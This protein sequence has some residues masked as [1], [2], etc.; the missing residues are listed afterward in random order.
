[1]RPFR[2]RPI[3][4]KVALLIGAASAMGLLF[5]GVAVLVYELTTFRPRVLQDARTQAEIIRVNSI[6]PLQFNDATAARENLATL[7]NRSEIRSARIW[8]P[9]GRLFAAYVRPGATP[10]TPMPALVAGARFLGDRLV[11]VE[12]MEADGQIIGWLTLQYTTPPLWRRLPQY[13]IMVIVVI[14]ALATAG[15]LLLSMLGRSVSAPL[16]RLADA[17]GTIGRTGNY[18]LQVPRGSD[19][20]IGRLTNAFNQL[21]T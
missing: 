7:E 3:R 16:L 18:R 21:I 11:L 9:D 19:D 14:V 12:P 2:D 1:M 15:G 20:E 5:A 13:G 17:A 8:L 4:Q 6:A 10:I